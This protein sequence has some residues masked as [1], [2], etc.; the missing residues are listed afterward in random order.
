MLP[1]VTRRNSFL[2]STM[3]KILSWV[4]RGGGADLVASRFEFTLLAMVR[5]SFMCADVGVI[6]TRYL[7]AGSL[8]C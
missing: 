5:H 3:R 7:A 2:V 4:C 1:T 8:C 6:E